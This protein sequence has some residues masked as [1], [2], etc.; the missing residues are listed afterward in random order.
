MILEPK[1][2]KSVTVSIVSPSIYHEVMGP[3]AMIF[4]FLECW[5]LNQPF[6]TGLELRK[7]SLPRARGLWGVWEWES[8]P[9]RVRGV[10]PQ[11]RGSEGESQRPKPGTGQEKVSVVEG[12][13][14]ALQS[15]LWEEEI[16]MLPSYDQEWGEGG[17][18]SSEDRQ[19]CSQ[20]SSCSSPGFPNPCLQH[21]VRPGL[22]FCF[23]RIP[24]WE[25]GVW[26][27][28]VR[29]HLPPQGLNGG[30]CET[31]ERKGSVRPVGE[32]GKYSLGFLLGRGQTL[33]EAP[34]HLSWSYWRHPNVPLTTAPSSFF[35]F[36]FS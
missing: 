15:S 13:L 9:E 25:R 6:C 16:Q 10:H 19:G 29:R 31:L 11:S 21:S 2:I 4:F 23:S 12:N 3:N 14:E 30:S 35:F 5:V 26:L 20:V 8:L 7:S 18:S 28:A 1:E 22:W 36:F 24:E 32:A 33:P 27:D 17:C 34:Q